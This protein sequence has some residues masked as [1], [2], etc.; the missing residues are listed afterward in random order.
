MAKKFNDASIAIVTSLNTGH[1]INSING[2][3][4]ELDRI[5]VANAI[6][7]F[8]GGTGPL[9]YAALITQTGTSAPSASP[10]AINTLGVTI[11]FSRNGVGD[12]NIN[13]SGAVFTNDKTMVFALNGDTPIAM[14]AVKMSTTVI[15]LKVAADDTI[16]Y[17]SLKIEVYP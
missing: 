17:A 12:Y 10:V 4:G 13:A 15:N 2:S 3:T 9:V 7:Q 14:C 6:T 11:T 8:G 1:Y 5:T 16:S